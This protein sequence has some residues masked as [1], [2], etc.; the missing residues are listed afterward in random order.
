MPAP[1]R[2][3]FPDSHHQA[4]V[5]ARRL[6]RLA[7]RPMRSE[8]AGNARRCRPCAGACFRRRARSFAKIVR[9]GRQVW[10]KISAA[11]LAIFAAVRNRCARLLVE[12]GAVAE[13][14]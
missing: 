4:P 7:G 12:E 13:T 3:P 1:P 14:S 9:H 2:L 11:M 10:L 5:D 6:V 8:A